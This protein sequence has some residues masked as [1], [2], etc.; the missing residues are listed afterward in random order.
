[1]VGDSEARVVAVLTRAPSAGGKRRLF[2]DLDRDPDPAL[3]EAL[4]LDTIDGAADPRWRT[5]AVV[6]PAAACPAVA[7][8]LGPRATAVPQRGDTLGERMGAAMADRFAAGARAVVLVGS[9]LP[10]ITRAPIAE[11]FD[12]IARHPGALVMG[13]ASDG[14]FYLIG[15]DAVPPALD[16][17]VWGGPTVLRDTIAACGRA[18]VPVHLVRPLADVDTVADLRALAE[19]GAAAGVSARRTRAWARQHLP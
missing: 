11:A 9:D 16:G 15:G 10:T 4:L 14:G 8:L 2:A 17:V 3:L 18:G 19:G 13:P 12:A 5:V 6:E 1:M 7:A